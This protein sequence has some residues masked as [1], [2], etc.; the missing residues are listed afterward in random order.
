MLSCDLESMATETMSHPYLAYS[1]S[2]V[3]YNHCYRE[4]LRNASV[5]LTDCKTYIAEYCGVS[6][7]DAT[8]NRCQEYISSARKMHSGLMDLVSANFFMDT[9]FNRRIYSN[10]RSHKMRSFFAHK[11]CLSDV[12]NHVSACI[13]EATRACQARNVHV[14]YTTSLNMADVEIIIQQIP[15]MFVVHVVRDPRD[16]VMS[17]SMADIMANS[18]NWTEA[19]CQRML[20]DLKMRHQL[21]VKYPGVFLQV[22]HEDVVSSAFRVGKIL[23]EKLGKIAP[24]AEWEATIGAENGSYPSGYNRTAS[25]SGNA[26]TGSSINKKYD[27]QGVKADGSGIPGVCLDVLQMLGYSV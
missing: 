20:V 10:S 5:S 3:D 12:S 23:Y 18:A 16:T 2:L 1:K 14:L 24:Y 15:T 27:W 9:L 22:K 8:A 11:V 26:A 25:G 4:Q 21:E 17:I 7:D 6:L 19:I 13:Q